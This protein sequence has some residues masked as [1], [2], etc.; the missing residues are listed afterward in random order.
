MSGAPLLELVYDDPPCMD[1]KRLGMWDPAMNSVPN[2]SQDNQ[3]L[4]H[5]ANIATNGPANSAILAT[6][7][8]ESVDRRFENSTKERIEHGFK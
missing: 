5:S 4:P 1:F 8:T 2:G 3:H 7:N 6:V